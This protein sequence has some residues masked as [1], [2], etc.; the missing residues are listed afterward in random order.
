MEKMKETVKG[1]LTAYMERN[2]CRKTPERYAILDEIYSHP[3]H[4]TVDSL[5]DAMVKKKYRVCRATIY[6][7]LELLLDCNLIVRHRFGENAAHFERAYYGDQHEH[8][9]CRK[10]GK[11]GEFSDPRI[12]EIVKTAEKKYGFRGH[13]HA[14]YIYGLC[15]ECKES[16]N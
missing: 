13:S 6:N 2:N 16:E 15:R 10:C 4:F 1:I 14:L 12:E 11:V 9:I 5:L 7:T 8:L 3:S